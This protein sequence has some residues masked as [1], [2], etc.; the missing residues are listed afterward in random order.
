MKEWWLSQG[1]EKIRLPVPPNEFEIKTG[2]LNST[3]TVESLGEV[4]FLGKSMLATISVNSF[5]PSKEYSF[6]QYKGFIKPYAA[7]KTFE[8]WRLSDKPIRLLITGTNV[9]TLFSIDGFS[10]SER[11]GSKDVY[12]SL[13]LKEYR[14]IK[15]AKEPGKTPSKPKPA[16]TRTVPPKN[17]KTYTVKKGDTL[18]VIAKRF[19]GSSSKYTILVKKNNIKNPNRIYPGQVL[20]L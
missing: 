10:N 8:K 18:C 9:N 5:W 16:P 20:K 13:D 11:D 7:V 14:V 17:Q 3:V 2:N 1:N 12:F 19:Y 6:C 4:S 15:V